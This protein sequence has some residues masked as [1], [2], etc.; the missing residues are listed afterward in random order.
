[1]TP[2]FVENKKAAHFYGIPMRYMLSFKGS[3]QGASVFCRK[4]IWEEHLVSGTGL[5]PSRSTAAI[6]R[7]PCDDICAKIECAVL[8]CFCV[9]DEEKE[10]VEEN[11][12]AERPDHILPSR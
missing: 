12:G 5:G 7:P 11:A 2:I 3:R 6:T 9:I 10:N 4:S 1:M 8:V